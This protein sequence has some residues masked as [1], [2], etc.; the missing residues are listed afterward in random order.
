MAE[1]RTGTKKRQQPQPL[2]RCDSDGVPYQ[3]TAEVEAQIESA[4][5][6][7]PVTLVE[8]AQLSDQES[9]HFLREESLIY[10]IREYHRLG[11]ETAV[12]ELAEVLIA[13][14]AKKI[15]QQLIALTR[16]SRIEAYRDVIE[17]LFQRILDL[18]SD[19]ADFMEVRF[20]VVVKRLTI[21]VFRQ[22]T[23]SL[24]KEQGVDSFS[25]IE[26][27]MLGGEGD[28]DPILEERLSASGLSVEENA[29][30]HEAMGILEEPY[31]TAFLLRIAYGWQIESNNPDVPTISEYFDKTPRTIR[32]WLKIAKDQMREW[33]DERDED[34]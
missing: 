3:R 28:D 20:W 29:L 10:F 26:R 18:K 4:V 31:R 30:L 5:D 19:R 22:H 23:S 9:P 27:S 2:S 24:I 1:R 34:A 21:D 15:Q 11:N 8:R 14:C 6:L 7:D 13:R 33:R 17:A 25:D 32:G 16:A 12:S